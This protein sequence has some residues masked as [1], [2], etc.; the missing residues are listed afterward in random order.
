MSAELKSHATNV[1]LT[2]FSGGSRGTCVQVT[3]P[4]SPDTKAAGAFSDYIQLTRGQA[5]ALAADLLDFAQG[6][7]EEDNI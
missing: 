4:A 1:S 6:R 2:R 7:E 5:A 3:T